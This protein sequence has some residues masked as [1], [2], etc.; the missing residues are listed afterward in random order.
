MN[1]KH[2]MAYF[3]LYAEALKETFR[4]L[5][6][7]LPGVLNHAANVIRQS[8]VRIRNIT[9]TL[10]DHHLS[11]LVQSSD[12]RCGSGAS[13]HSAH[14]NNFHGF[15]PPFPIFS[16]IFSHYNRSTGKNP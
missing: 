5:Q 2:L 12:S 1:R 9:G 16:L 7:Q 6:S 11:V 13:G 15:N 8:A 14:N 3:H 4:C 10:K